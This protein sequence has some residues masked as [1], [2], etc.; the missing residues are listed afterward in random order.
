MTGLT[1][2]DMRDARMESRE[3]IVSPDAHFAQ[4]IGEPFRFV[5]VSYGDELTAHFGD[6]RPARSPKLKG[7]FYGS[8]ILGVRCSSWILKSGS[9]PLIISAGIAAKQGAKTFGEPLSKEGLETGRFVEPGSRVIEASPFIVKPVE[10]FGLQLRM[11]DGS[12]L[13]VLPTS[14]EADSDEGEDANE[15]E[16]LPALPD[17]ELTTPRGLLKA[18]PDLK[19]SFIDLKR[20]S[21]MRENEPAI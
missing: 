12:T 14:E 13:L 6:L 2:F 3:H 18:G 20:S 8:Y 16:N 17:W 11:S 5:R 4:L 9:A 1:L 21:N 15:E 7:K 19:W 10:G